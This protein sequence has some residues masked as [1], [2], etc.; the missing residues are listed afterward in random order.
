MVSNNEEAKARIRQY[1]KTEG[2]L[3]TTL[4]TLQIGDQIGEG[5][6]SLVY[7]AAYSQ[8]G[9][10]VVKFLM[11]EC[12][13]THSK[14]YK[15]FLTEI[16]ELMQLSDTGLVASVHQ[17]GFLETE[18]G[19][20]PY[21]L[22][23]QYPCTLKEWRQATMP[24]TWDELEPILMS[25]IDALQLIHERGIIHRDIKPENI[26]VTEGSRAVVGDFGIAW[27]DPEHYKR[28]AL[29][30]KGERLANFAFSAPEQFCK[31][32]RPH[33]T[34]DLYALGQ[35][36]QWLVTGESHRGTGRKLLATVD[37]SLAWLDSIVNALLQ[38]EPD[39]RPQS[40][41]ALR[42][43]LKEAVKSS[44]IA[45]YDNLWYCLDQFDR[46][47]CQN[48]PGK[49]GLF[50]VKDR[51]RIGEIVDALGQE[52][53]RYQI[54]LGRGLQNIQI[55]SVRG[56]G[57]DTWLINQIES[58]IDSIWVNKDYSDYRH[59]MVLETA[60]MPSFRFDE[61][62]QPYEDAA[63]FADR[64][65]SRSEYDDGFAEIDGRVVELAGKAEPRA[66]ETT[67]NFWFVGTLGS[68]I[69]WLG[70][71]EMVRKVHQ[72]L[73]EN[74]AVD[75]DILA[76]LEWL[77]TQ[78]EIRMVQRSLAIFLSHQWPILKAVYECRIHVVPYRF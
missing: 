24:G 51:R 56:L 63:W 54:W 62:S 71:D 16:R 38:Q 50:Q 66:R 46:F 67:R 78:P 73:I 5:A 77:S 19:T 33:Q 49:R 44:D 37:P 28:L 76:E 52:A 59:Y 27:F 17:M 30:S 22:M 53:A 11:E 35:L 21:I 14:R 32:P 43:M 2:H 57:K 41:S 75:A 18:W 31:E 15:R 45:Q 47:L 64:Y 25:L 42:N 40:A 60:P 1:V 12:S 8:T 48:F 72:S 23:K 68:N 70:N 20:Y 55:R 74:D 4:G 69:S 3:D 13:P 10:L 29:T 7:A 61:T 26:F 65:I 36:I 34:M 9:Q 39:S 6:N 58:I